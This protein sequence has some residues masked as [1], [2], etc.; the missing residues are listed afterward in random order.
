VDLSEELNTSS[1]EMPTNNEPSHFDDLIGD[2]E[3][4]EKEQ[5]V[6]KTLVDRETFRK[7]FIGLHKAGATFTGIQSLA[8]PNT[9]IDEMTADEIADVFYETI[10]DIPML[11][12]FLK[13]NNK[14]IGRGF[15]MI[16]YVKGM[17]GAIRDEIGSRQPKEEKSK[18]QT[19]SHNEPKDG[20][21]DQSQAMAL[22]GAS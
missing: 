1:Q 15:I 2:I 8:L 9:R 6:E 10:L 13:P 11:H 21:P 18:P 20:S 14:W 4:E 19:Q 17:Q 16:M 12:S 22:V 7:S 3:Q 5:F